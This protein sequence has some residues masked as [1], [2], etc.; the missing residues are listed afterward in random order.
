MTQL[1]CP[2]NARR[3]LVADSAVNGIDHVEVLPSRRAL[4]VHCFSAPSGLDAENVVIEG[5]VRIRTKVLSVHRGD[6]VPTGLLDPPD[7]LVLSRIPDPSRVLVVRTDQPGDFSTYTLQL[8]PPE[9]AQD[10]FDPVLSSAPFSY[11]VD[12][13]SD[14]D[15]GADEACEE[16]LWPAPQID[17]MAKDYASFRSLMLDRLSVLAPDWE[18]RNPADVMTALVELLA[19]SADSLSYFQDA[20]ATEAYLGTARRRESVRRH[21]RLVDYRM[22]DGANARTWVCFETDA[23]ADGAVLEAGTPVLTGELGTTVTMSETDVEKAVSQGAVVFETMHDLTLRES[24]NAIPFYTWGDDRC[25]LP[26]GATRAT[27]AGN[28]AALDLRGGDVLILEEVLNPR[29]RRPEDADRTHRHPVRLRTAPVPVRDPVRHVW[30][31]EVEWHAED[32][33]PFPLCLWQ[34]HDT[35]EPVTTVPTSVARGN[36]ALADHGRTLKA[37]QGGQRRVLLE[38][39]GTPVPGRRFRPTLERTGLTHAVE[40]DHDRAVK[41]AAARSTRYDSLDTALPAIAVVGEQ[42][43]WEPL[44]ELLNSDRFAANFVVEM[45]E[46][47]RASLRFGDGVLGREPAVGP[48]YASYRIGNGRGGNVGQGAL[49]R[50]VT[51][52]RVTAL[53]NPVAATGGTDPEPIETVRLNAPQAFRTQRRAVTESDYVTRAEQHPE[54]QKAGA[55]RRWTGSWYTMFVTI[56]RVGGREIDPAFEA[57]MRAHLDVFRLA[58]H[59]VEIDAPRYVPLELA[60]TVAVHPGYVR[61]GVKEALLEAFGNRPLSAD[62]RGFFHPDNFSFGQPVHL[63][64]I[65]AAAMGVSGVDWVEVTRFHRFDHPSGDSLDKGRV[66]LA[67]LEV[68]RLDNDPN[69]PENG[70]LELDLRGGL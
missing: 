12:C 2:E 24:R 39:L 35:E 6:Q 47:G 28:A 9:K 52:V 31:L 21:A 62:R 50:V 45:H 29:N 10:A 37:M 42:E 65:V 3:A 63:S 32:A 36:V 11:M 49:R 38:R 1:H 60:M 48:F 44:H 16:R 19:Y 55:T 14:F 13:E 67:R 68:A 25:C 18:E 41:V 40:Y 20:V 33:L 17:Y 66:E 64:R 57:E 34:F 43:P 70:R 54:V 7:G 69:R 22:H 27:L 61:S 26:A 56:D 8:V 23:A 30:A 4:L 59:D 58:G 15:C 5:G 51:D 46:D 53:T